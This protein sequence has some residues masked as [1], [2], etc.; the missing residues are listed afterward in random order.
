METDP[1]YQ[2]QVQAVQIRGSMVTC[3]SRQ[4]MGEWAEQAIPA[5]LLAE[6]VSPHPQ[7]TI[8]QLHCGCGLAGAVAARLAAQ[9]S[10]TLLDDNIVAV[11]AARQTLAANQVANAQVVLSDCAQAVR[12]RQFDCVLSVMPKGR[13]AWEQTILD[14]AQ[15]LRP[16]GTLYLA[17]ANK[18]GI[19][20]AAKFIDQIL[21]RSS[22]LAYRGGCRVLYA[23]KTQETTLPGSD[24]YDWRRVTAQ[25]G[26]QEVVYATK[27]GLFSWQALDDGTHLL[28]EALQASPLDGSDRVLD[29]GCGCGVLTLVAARQAVQGSALGVDVDCRAVEATRRTIGLN[30]L[31]N[32]RA[33]F[34]DCGQALQG[35][36]FTAVITNPPFHQA[37]A[38]TY[39]VA[40]QII[41]EAA[42]LLAA[43][44]R[45]YLVA[46][47]F[48]RYGPIIQETF[49]NA[50][51]LLQNNRFTVWHAIKNR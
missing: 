20:S 6:Q 10:A 39:V 21:G 25:V 4:A 16:G 11:E 29:I 48:L 14:A 15:V 3:F 17:G 41:R 49:G 35:G 51:V 46:N 12:D 27:P 22:V 34:S 2:C 9:G 13:A 43:G 7:A 40:T 36:L 24:Y 31:H 23:S 45:L 47:R 5:T 50:S 28:I 8:L 44:G 37:Q 26:G 19:K 18:S 32:A 30:A 1:Y 33:M 42:R 38:T